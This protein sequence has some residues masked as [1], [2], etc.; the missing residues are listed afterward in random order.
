MDRGYTGQQF[1][2]LLTPGS[3]DR[4]VE[5]LFEQEFGSLRGVL[6]GCQCCTSRYKG[7]F[8]SGITLFTLCTL[9]K[10]EVVID[11]EYLTGPMVKN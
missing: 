6:R 9:S 7:M 3:A 11:Y 8:Y 2:G 1:V 5:N 4:Q 10:M